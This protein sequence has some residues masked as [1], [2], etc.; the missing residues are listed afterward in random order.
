MT[1]AWSAAALA[2]LSLALFSAFEAALTSLGHIRLLQWVGK[3]MGSGDG[4]QLR[5]RPQSLVT[6]TFVG[7]NLS[8]VCLAVAVTPLVGSAAVLADAS[9]ILVALAVVA[10][11]TPPAVL[12]GEVVPRAAVRESPTAVLRL[13]FSAG[14]ALSWVFWPYIVLMQAVAHM[15]F[16]VLGLPAPPQERALTR[17]SVEALL[18]EGEREGLVDRHEREIIGGIFSFGETPVRDV[19]TPRPDVVTVQLGESRRSLARRIAETG[20]SRFPVTDGAPDN[21]V[22]IVHAV[23][24]LKTRDG[25]RLRLRPTL[26][27]PETA[28]CDELLVSMRRQRI[29]L[30]VAVDEYGGVAGIVTMEDLVEELVGEIRDEHDLEEVDAVTGA[31]GRLILEGRVRLS[32]VADQFPEAFGAVESGEED[33]R[34]VAGWLLEELG[35]VPAAGERAA[36]PGV[37]VE[38]LEATPKRILRLGLTRVPAPAR[39]SG[40]EARSPRERRR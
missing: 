3:R 25:E 18:R 38:V 40:Q 29:Q 36:L 12:L 4:A 31:D 11:A 17:D 32:E 24:V 20:F 14:R 9:P 23:D 15:L 8:K 30:A 34:T 10:L 6:M 21:I 33:D 27:V 1:P 28:T 26:F 2:L 7:S 22:G 35:R 19:M 16:K 13:L 39:G 37:A 5:E